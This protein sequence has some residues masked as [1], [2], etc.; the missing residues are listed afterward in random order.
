MLVDLR[1]A[2]I[3]YQDHHILLQVVAPASRRPQQYFSVVVEGRSSS[4]G[5]SSR[6][7]PLEKAKATPVIDMG[8]LFTSRLYRNRSFLLQNH[9]DDTLELLLRRGPSGDE[10][11]ELDFS[12]TNTSLKKCPEVV[13]EPRSQVRVYIFCRFGGGERDAAADGTGA[14]EEGV[15]ITLPFTVR[16]RLSY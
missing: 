10:R 13:V 16:C 3:S 14:A 11:H 8:R 12:R 6:A 9:S 2:L 1:Q 4:C 5:G 15:E 7:T